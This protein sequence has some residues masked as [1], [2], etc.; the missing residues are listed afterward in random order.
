MSLKAIAFAAAV[1]SLGLAGTA[2]A[3]T[4]GA[5]IG[6]Q[7]TGNPAVAQAALY[8]QYGTIR[9]GRCVLKYVYVTNGYA[10]RY[11]WRKTCR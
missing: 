11:R 8:Y 10:W 7:V 6:P 9:K 3:A 5:D 2:S 4:P 1:L